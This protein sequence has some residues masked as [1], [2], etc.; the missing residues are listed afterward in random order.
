[1]GTSLEAIMGSASVQGPLW[2]ARAEDWAELAEPVQVTFYEAVFDALDVGPTTRL[3]DVGC[4]A[5]LALQIA[6][7][8]GAT[9]AGLDAAE[10]PVAVARRGSPDADV[11]LGDLEQRQRGS[12]ESKPV[13]APHSA[14]GVES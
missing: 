2:G 3:L 12:P 7:K 8:R 5:G 14:T 11:R 10:G 4:G 13:G 9:V 1:M 6:A